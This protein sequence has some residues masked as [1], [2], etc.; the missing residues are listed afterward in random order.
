[1]LNKIIIKQKIKTKFGD[2]T[3]EH[4]TFS[5]VKVKNY[6]ELWDWLVEIDEIVEDEFEIMSVCPEPKLINKNIIGFIEED[7]YN[8]ET[9]RSKQYH[10]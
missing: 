2:Y 8:K 7:M 9:E 5:D 10:S 3:I 6:N 1:M 4:K